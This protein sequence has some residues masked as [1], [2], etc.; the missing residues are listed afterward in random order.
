MKGMWD[1]DW[2]L[3]LRASGSDSKYCSGF[4]SCGGREREREGEG[5]RERNGSVYLFLPIHTH[6][7]SRTLT[8]HSRSRVGWEIMA[9][10]FFII[11]VMS[12]L[13][14]A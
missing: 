12:F 11:L 5:E 2:R 13:S 6:N 14:A 10:K 4:I 1:G 9:K 3:N 8:M 7:P